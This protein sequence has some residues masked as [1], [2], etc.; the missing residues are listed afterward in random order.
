[1]KK[2]VVFFIMLVNSVFA[3]AAFPQS[4]D[5]QTREKIAVYVTGSVGNNEK[6]ALGTKIL[7]ELTNSGRYRAVERS[8]D[9]V[10]ELDR[11]QSKQM[12][13]AVDDNEI[14]RIGKQFGVQV[15]CIADLTRAFG[16]NQ[17]SA[18][19]IDVESAEIMAIAEVTNPL[20]SI[21]DLTVASKKVVRGILGLEKGRKP[22]FGRPKP[23]AP[24]GAAETKPA[25]IPAPARVYADG[26][27]TDM[28]RF[29][30]YGLNWIPGLGSFV[31]MKDNIGG[32]IQ[33][34]A[35]AAGYTLLFSG[36][37]KQSLN[38]VNASSNQTGTE[39][40]FKLNGMF[41]I[42]FGV[43]VGNN[44]FDVYRSM[45]Y[46][47]LSSRAA[48]GGADGIRFAVLPDSRDGVNAV[49]LYSKSF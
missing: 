25:K 28:Q 42:G 4:P 48:A 37:S 30:T 6:K 13:G 47:K 22:L 43:L 17:I 7:I 10:R 20:E 19:L 14:T 27:F 44:V 45:T 5:A 16:S 3:P 31:V 39:T 23:K 24:E 18:R 38:V 9:F 35:G 32:L 8:D 41:W 29:K 33:L 21:E 15:I 36:I 34:G 11:E 40:Q 12:S 49:V 1:M 26:D 46:R 2:P